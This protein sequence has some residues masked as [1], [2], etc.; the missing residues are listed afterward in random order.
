MLSLTG[1]A[2]LSKLAFYPALLLSFPGLDVAHDRLAEAVD[3]QPV[4]LGSTGDHVLDVV[5]VARAV[6]V[7]V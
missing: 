7:G 3:P 1:F 5:G 4:H 6:N 2:R